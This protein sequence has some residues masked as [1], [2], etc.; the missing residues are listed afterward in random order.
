[1]KKKKIKPKNKKNRK[2]ILEKG[3]K[4]LSLHYLITY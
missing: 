1:M 2:K 4:L 3:E